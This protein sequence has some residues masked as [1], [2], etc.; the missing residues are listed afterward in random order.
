[1]CIKMACSRLLL[2]RSSRNN[3]YQYVSDKGLPVR[4]QI[5]DGEIKKS[6]VVKRGDPT[7]GVLNGRED[8]KDMSLIR[9][10]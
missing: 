3:E 5:F 10:S 2:D 9:C 7:K 4:L 6:W 8:A 1:M